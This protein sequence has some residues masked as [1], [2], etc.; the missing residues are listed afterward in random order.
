MAS[1][2]QCVGKWQAR[3]QRK[4]YPDEVAP[5]KTKTEAQTWAR[6]IESAIDQGSY[7]SMQSAKD[8]LL[9][10]VLRRYM[11]EV[12]PSKRGAQREAEGIQFMRRQKIE[13]YSM[14]NL[15]PAVIAGYR[16]ERLKTIAPHARALRIGRRAA[17]WKSLRG[18]A[19]KK[20]DTPMK[21][22]TRQ[23]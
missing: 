10:D 8:L 5:F 21:W 15:T 4:G 16:D 13:A 3:V 1:I 22:P 12:T 18:P 9:A 17:P 23:Q 11:N 7:Q 2:R 20:T 14:A 19:H 6:S